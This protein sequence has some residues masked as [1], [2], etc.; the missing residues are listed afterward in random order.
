MNRLDLEPQPADQPARILL[1][2]DDSHLLAIMAEVIGR[3]G[4]GADT[5]R[6]GTEAMDCLQRGHYP[7]VVS[8]I[9]LP[10]MDGRALLQHIHVHCRATR[11]ILTPRPDE[12]TSA[13]ELLRAGAADVLRKP[14]RLTDLEA[15]I[16]RVLGALPPAGGAGVVRRIPPAACPGENGPDPGLFEAITH[17]VYVIDIETYTVL[18]ANSSAGFGPLVGHPLCYRLT[19]GSD[20]PCSGPDGPCP[21]A[22]VKRTG[23]PATVEHRHRDSRGNEYLVEV[24]AYPIR[25]ERGV[26]R[27]VLEYC[28]DVTGRKQ[29]TDSPAQATSGPEGAS[30][31]RQILATASHEIRTPMAAIL[32]VSQ[33][34]LETRLT[35]EQHRYLCV[36]QNSAQAMMKIID[37][38]LDLSKAEAGAV[39]LERQPFDLA[40]TVA[41]CVETLAAMAH[42]KGIDLRCQLADDLPTSV[43]GDSGRLRQVLLNLVGNAVKFTHQGHV[44]VHVECLSQERGKAVLHFQV[45]DTGIGIPAEAQHLIFTSYRQ[46]DPGISRSYGGTGLGLAICR[47][48]VTLFG[49]EIWVESEPGAGSTFHVTAAF[50]LLSGQD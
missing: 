6:D 33:L 13:S 21:L 2:G 19:H 41:G 17:P 1:A 25:D 12:A 32:G 44:A 49:G 27:R 35:P 28:L 8:D 29:A 48:L 31:W 43:V 23:Q 38:L 40:A 24:H 18:Y 22:I 50:D 39:T 47:Q 14:F 7:L 34:A 5:A 30:L 45:A 36:V 16:R 15:K 42:R 11:V 37:N 20:Q 46:A 4:Y 26:P 10:G 9:G 3:L